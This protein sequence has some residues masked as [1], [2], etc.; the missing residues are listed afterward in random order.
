MRMFMK[1]NGFSYTE[2]K[3]HYEY[4]R[5][6]SDIIE[7]RCDYLDY[8]SEYREKGYQV[9]WQDETWVFKNMSKPK[10]WQ[11][12]TKNSILYNNYK[13]PSGSGERAIVCHLGSSETGLLDGCELCFHG[14]KSIVS[15]YHSEMNWELF[16]LWLKSLVFPKLKEI[17]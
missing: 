16:S 12:I 7:M 9:F 3:S 4:T 6:R 10:V 1:K 14:K 2:R 13:V 5:E 11:I 8:I 17:G 15:D